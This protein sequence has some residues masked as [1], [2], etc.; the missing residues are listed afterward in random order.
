LG[1][2]LEPQPR[3][4]HT[5]ERLGSR[6]GKLAHDRPISSRTGMLLMDEPARL[7]EHHRRGADGWTEVSLTSG[8]AEL[9]TLG[10]VLLLDDVYDLA[11]RG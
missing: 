8:A 6:G 5:D 10:G 1:E 9:P 11:D 3:A 2:R 4:R 7:V